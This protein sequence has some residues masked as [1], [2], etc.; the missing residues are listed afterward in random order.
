MFASVNVTPF[1]Y[2]GTEPTSKLTC[3][4]V[5][6]HPLGVSQEESP[7]ASLVKTLPT[8]G[9]P[10]VIFIEGTITLF[11]KVLSP[12]I[13]STPVVC[14]RPEFVFAELSPVFVQLVFHITTSCESV[15]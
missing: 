5:A 1:E 8:Q 6:H 9:E 15:T 14:T 4:I 10:H 12:P 3:I 11:E 13:V 2:I 7:S